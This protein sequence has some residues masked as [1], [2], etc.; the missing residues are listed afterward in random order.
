VLTV[1]DSGIGGADPAGGT[2]L[3]GLA[4]RVAVV[5]GTLCLT[6]PLGGPT[7]LRVE[8]PWRTTDCG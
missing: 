1:T 7:E 2:G 8:L 6:S 4:D 3:Q 5:G